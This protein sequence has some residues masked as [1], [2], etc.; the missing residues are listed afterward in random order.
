MDARETEARIHVLAALRE[1]PEK[2]ADRWVRLQCEQAAPG[3]GIS[4]AELRQEADALVDALRSGLESDQPADRVVTTHPVLR[5]A[6][7]EL[8]LSR[9]RS[10][11]SPTATSLAVPALKESLLEA[12]QHSTRDPGALHATA[13]LVNRLLDP[14]GALSFETY[15]A[16]R[17]EIVRRQSRQL[18]EVSTP[19]VRLWDKVLAVPLIGTLD[20]TRAQVVM[21]N[22]LEAIERE[23]A[24]AAILDITGVST[25][26]TVVAH[27]LMRTVDAVRLMGADC[28]ISGIRPPIA[29]TIAELGIDL[30]PVLTHATLADAL[31]AATAL[32]ERPAQPADSAAVV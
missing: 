5:R 31:A 28:V 10:G 19:V 3:S 7:V 24:Q 18:L 12:V 15:A 27:H 11:A 17:E 2:V 23:E 25:V 16:G 4:E 6:I 1:R 21:E 32:T 20:S 13:L 9:A 26:D 30:S 29:R 14:A 8:S 22:L